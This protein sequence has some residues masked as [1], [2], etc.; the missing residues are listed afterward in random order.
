M[1]S[2][3]QQPVVVD[4]RR[5]IRRKQT[6]GMHQHLRP[7]ISVTTRDAGNSV[8]TRDAGNSVTT[9]DAG[10]SVTTRDA[11][12]SVTTCDAGISKQIA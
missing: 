11:G 1:L 6:I 2:P 4:G 8:T 10:I 7:L 9:R 5:V 3:G 12:I